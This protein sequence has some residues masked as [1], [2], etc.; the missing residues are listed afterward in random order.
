MDVEMGRKLADIQ[1]EM[2]VRCRLVRFTM[3][4]VEDRI[5]TT[6]PSP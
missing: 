5:S 2:P 1:D 4:V 3:D 6:R